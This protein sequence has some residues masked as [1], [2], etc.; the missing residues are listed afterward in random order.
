MVSPFLDHGCAGEGGGERLGTHGE[1]G[2]R[3]G[4][5]ASGPLLLFSNRF[6]FFLI[7]FTRR[8]DS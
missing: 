5:A 8:I 1:K 7:T 6:R 4:R 2:G 3:S